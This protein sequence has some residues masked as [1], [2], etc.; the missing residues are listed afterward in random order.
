MFYN[1]WEI[2]A[3]AIEGQ[4]SFKLQL[5]VDG[6]ALK[7]LAINS[8][9]QAKAICKG[10]SSDSLHQIGA[11]NDCLITQTQSTIDSWYADLGCHPHAFLAL[12]VSITKLHLLATDSHI[13]IM[14]H[15][16]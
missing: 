14:G 8:A 4:G 10:M 7:V 15:S 5:T 6:S 13:H 12:H 16:L 3:C 9:I 2:E 1:I 11:L